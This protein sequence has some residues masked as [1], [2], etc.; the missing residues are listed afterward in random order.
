MLLLI[1]LKKLQCIA[2]PRPASVCRPLLNCFILLLICFFECK[3]RASFLKKK[4]KKLIQIKIP[5]KYAKFYI[6][7]CHFFFFYILNDAP[8][9][10]FCPYKFTHNAN[11][12]LVESWVKD[13]KKKKRQKFKRQKKIKEILIMAKIS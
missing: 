6:L 2:L 5:W 13:L 4:K 9:K 8:K 12:L 11:E 3:Y 10:D 7:R 1:L